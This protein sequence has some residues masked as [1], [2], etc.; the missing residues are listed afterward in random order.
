MSEILKVAG[1]AALVLIFQ[2]AAGPMLQVV[3]ARPD[4]LL[5]YVL[6]I[7]LQRGRI[8]GLATGLLAGL[9]MDFISVGA[10]GVYAL[11]KS[12]IAFWTG[13][14]LDDRVGSVALGWWMLI[15]FAASAGQG[16]FVGSVSG[17]GQLEFIPHLFRIVIPSTLYTCLVGLFWAIAP[18]GARSRGPLA[19]QLTRG[20]R[21]LR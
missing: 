2:V 13:M 3:G 18:M 10:I 9:A 1:M 8:A 17:S 6:L 5:I 14:W 11:A 12:T 19:P 4:F 15:L 7:T 20:R 21:S 16:I